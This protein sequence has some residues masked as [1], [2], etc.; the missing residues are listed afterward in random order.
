MSDWTWRLLD[1]E[2]Q[3]MRSTEPF[4]SQAA[5][6]SWMGAEWRALLDEGALYVELMNGHE[7]VYRMGL[8]EA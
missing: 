4:E 6:E 5:A 1:P 8:E 3:P 2:R 7:R